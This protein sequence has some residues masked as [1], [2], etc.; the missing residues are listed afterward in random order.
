M[1]ASAS[2]GLVKRVPSGQVRL[3][4]RFHPREMPRRTVHVPEFE[5]AHTVVTANQ[6]RG[7]V[8]DGGYQDQRWWMPDGWAWRQGQAVGWGRADRSQP[9]GWAR[10]CDR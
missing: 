10:Q 6:Y 1:N 8:A 7:F 9:D 3:G 5:M 2:I 4:S